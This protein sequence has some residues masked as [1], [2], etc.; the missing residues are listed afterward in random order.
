MIGPCMSESSSRLD[1]CYVPSRAYAYARRKPVSEG[2]LGWR[3]SD[4]AAGV[5][6]TPLL[7]IRANPPL[8]RA[9]LGV[10]SP[11]VCISDTSWGS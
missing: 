8:G 4:W 3:Q 5:L 6:I 10:I 11:I 2:G 9:V 7:L 1:A